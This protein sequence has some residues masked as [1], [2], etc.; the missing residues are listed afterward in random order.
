MGA[1]ITNRYFI[2]CRKSSEDEDRQVL[3]IESQRHELTDL[4]RKLDLPITDILTESKSAKAPGRK[5]FNDMVQRIHKGQATGIICWKLDRLAR[6]PIDGGQISWMLQQGIIR[7]IQTP[8]RSYYPEDNVLLMNVEFGMANQ[9]LRD[10]SKNTKRGLKAKVE[11]G[12]LPGL[13]PLGY[14]NNRYK[15]KGEKD[16]IKDPERFDF[17]RKMWDLMLSGHCT[18]PKIAEMANTEWGFRT[19]KFKRQGGKPLSRSII[20]KMFTDPFYCGMIRYSGE[21]YPGKHDPMVTVEEFDRVQIMLGRK[22]KPRPKT[23]HFPFRGMI[24]CGECGCFVTAEEKYKLTKSGVHHYIYHHCTKRKLAIRCSQPSM[25]EEEL[26]RQIK[27]E[28][29]KISI[30]EDF[31]NLAIRYLKKVHDKEVSSRSSI[32]K[33]L[34]ETCQDVQKQLHNLTALRLKEMISDEQ[35]LKH[36]NDLFKKK[37]KL[38]EK[39]GDTED[40][41]NRWLELS[42]RA[43]N[44]A[45]YAE[46]WFEN[47]KLEDKNTI[48]GTIGSNL[49]LKDSKLFIELK[50]PW[51]IIKRGLENAHAQKGRLEPSETLA[52]A[53]IEPSLSPVSSAWLPGQDS[54]LFY[55]P[56]SKY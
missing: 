16:I 32:K 28:L 17:A 55:L 19:R 1:M 41:P 21:L 39:I 14:L 22:G 48:L 50:N 54:N 24:R 34:H 5:A 31:K 47:G 51:L 43:F 40:K 2:Y 9:F 12:W 45:C 53:R 35:Y 44:F 20:Y 33:S 8:E 13:A 11:K 36:K 27:E 52:S 7:H 10:L 18:P 30:D 37:D 46:Y 25:R 4:A 38:K 49:I 23:H 56:R 26:E 6:N 3:S 42:E 15:A 29:S